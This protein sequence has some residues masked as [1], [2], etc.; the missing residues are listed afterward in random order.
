MNKN[1]FK[2][3]LKECELGL[4]IEGKIYLKFLPENF[5]KESPIAKTQINSVLHTKDSKILNLVNFKGLTCK[6]PY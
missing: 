2:L 3:H 4:I 5:R 6:N 1:M